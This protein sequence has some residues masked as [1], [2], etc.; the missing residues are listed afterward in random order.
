MHSAGKPQLLDHKHYCRAICFFAGKP[1]S[2]SKKTKKHSK[3]AMF[4]KYVY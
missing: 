4:L 1:S 2:R 3:L